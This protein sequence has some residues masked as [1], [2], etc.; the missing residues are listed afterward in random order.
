MAKVNTYQKDEELKVKFGKKELKKIAHYIKP[1]KKEFFFTFIILVIAMIAS[2]SMPYLIQNAL[3]VQ[4]PTGNVKGLLTI[5]II[6]VVI[7][8]ISIL[9][10]SLRMKYMNYVGQNIIFDM[11][12]DLF[13]TLQKLPFSYFDTRSH[14]KILVRVVNYVNTIADMFSSGLVTAVLDILSLIV[15]IYFMFSIS[16]KLS[17]IALAGVPLVVLAT[18]LIRKQQRRAWQ[19]YSNKNSNLTAY[20]HESI[21][22]IKITQAFV[23]E[24]KSS[25]IFSRLCT[26]TYRAFLDGKKY[27]LMRMPTITI[28]S[29]L[30]VCI[31]YYIGVA[32]IARDPVSMQVG[33]IVAMVAY[34]QRF[35]DPIKNIINLYNNIITNVAYL[36]R[37]VEMLDEPQELSD[38]EGAVT[39]PESKGNIT[40]ENVTFGY[41]EGINVLENVSFEVKSGETVALIGPT[42]AGKTTIVNLLGK[43][44]NLNGGRILVDGYDI[45]KVTLA[46]LRAQIG[47]MF[48]DS[49]LFSG[50]IMENIRYG[51]LD[52][53]D[54]EVYEAA[55]AVNAHNFII[56]LKNGYDTFVSERGSSLSVGQ[57]QLISL[58][59]TM[60]RNANILILDEATSNIDSETEAKLLLGM[61][62]LMEG[63][64]SFVIAHRLSTIKNADKI[65]VIANKG[66]EE[67]GTFD[68]L[69]EKKGRFYELYTK[70][71]SL[72]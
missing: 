51:R 2:T 45:S 71:H 38:P 24:K 5:G 37:I 66:I 57:R 33:V 12:K 7:T 27:E 68:E 46:S 4:I 48:Q 69:M 20:L 10:A 14:G 23:H 50:T 22:G 53:S 31:I 18:L 55:K 59:R 70:Q 11:R 13:K 42:G 60:L 49:F 39:L 9:A 8:I 65:M 17:L 54:E 35:W 61:N 64:T 36:D 32:A 41:E 21:N 16:P 47:Y 62:K 15:I 25:R 6:F 40:Y 26:E 30:T 52:A 56:G 34:I 3:D 44:Y 19:V 63:R 72:E 67:S 28:I 1:Y 29:D 43:Y 58:A